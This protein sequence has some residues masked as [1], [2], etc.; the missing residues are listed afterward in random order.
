MNYDAIKAISEAEA[1]AAKT[2]TDAAAEAKELLLKAETDGAAL[3]SQREAAAEEAGKR[4]VEA[5]EEA[6][7]AEAAKIAADTVAACSELEKK[8]ESNLDKAVSFIVGRIV[9]S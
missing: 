9:N 3:V 2:R 8:A 4:R 6:G 5:A 7:K 1:K